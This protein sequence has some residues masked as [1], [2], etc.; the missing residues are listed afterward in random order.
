M[1][2]TFPVVLGIGKRRFGE[3]DFERPTAAE[4]ERRRR[5][6]AR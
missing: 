1:Q 6:A 2:W 3:M 5:L 4:L